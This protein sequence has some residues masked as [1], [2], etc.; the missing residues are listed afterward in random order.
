[1]NKYEL[2]VIL[3][4]NL[5][6]DVRTATIEKVKELRIG[7]EK[8]AETLTKVGEVVETFAEDLD[9]FADD[10]YDIA[11]VGDEVVSVLSALEDGNPV[12]EEEE[13]ATTAPGSSCQTQ[14]NYSALLWLSSLILA[15]LL[16]IV[17]IILCLKAIKNRLKKN[18]KTKR[19]HNAKKQRNRH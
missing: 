13:D 11:S 12:D 16:I 2:A 1:M 7:I 8:D 15:V 3:N 9:E 10:I 5:E 4:V 18:E 14:L 6:E 19:Q 17:L